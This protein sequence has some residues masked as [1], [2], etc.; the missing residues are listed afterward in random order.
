MF[1]H[2]YRPWRNES[3]APFW[4]TL[5][6]EGPWFK[7]TSNQLLPLC[8]FCQGEKRY[9]I[10]H[11]SLRWS[12][13]DTA[14]PFAGPSYS[15]GDEGR[16]ARRQAKLACV[17]SCALMSRYLSPSGKENGERIEGTPWTSG[18]VC[19]GVDAAPKTP[20]HAKDTG[21]CGDPGQPAV[22]CVLQVVMPVGPSS[23]SI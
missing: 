3:R 9:K 22:E 12:Y 19:A 4:I 6:S 1:G 21:L 18:R 16:M 11:A 8:S 17:R 7:K 10:I 23:S 2:G 14:L 15:E 5:F 13:L 20:D